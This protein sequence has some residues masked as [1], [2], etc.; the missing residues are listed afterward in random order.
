MGAELGFPEIDGLPVGC[1]DGDE[2]GMSV[3]VK[4]GKED[5]V[6]DGVDEGEFDGLDEMLGRELGSSV[7]GPN[8]DSA[9]P[10]TV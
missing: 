3:G 1:S 2:D 5:G 9:N 7:S 4:E 8:I 6:F 10:E